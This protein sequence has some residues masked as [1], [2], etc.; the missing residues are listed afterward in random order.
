MATSAEK[1][2]NILGVPFKEYV[3]N[4]IN[5][6]SYKGST[7]ERSNEEIIYLSNK[8]CWIRLLSS[9]DINDPLNGIVGNQA[10]KDWILFGGTSYYDNG[11]NL[12]SGI[13]NIFDPNFGSSK[14][15]YGLGGVKELGFRPMPG[16]ISANIE[17]AGRAGSLRFADIKIK[18]W[19]KQQ[20]DNIEKLYF[21]LGYSCLLE[22]GHSV[23]LD[24]TGR[25]VPSSKAVSPIDVFGS[26][27][28]GLYSTKE[29][30]ITAINQKKES[31]F[32]NY[33]GLFGIIYNY[34]WSQAGDGSYDCTLKLVGIGSIIDSLK[35]NQAYSM[36]GSKDK[37]S[38]QQTNNNSVITK[39]SLPN[40][41]LRSQESYVSEDDKT[42]VFPFFN[43][44]A[45]SGDKNKGTVELLYNDLKNNNQAIFEIRY[46]TQDGKIIKGKNI[47]VI[48]YIDTK[49]ITTYNTS[50]KG[51][52]TL[53]NTEQT[54]IEKRTITSTEKIKVY[55]NKTFET[56]RIYSQVEKFL[57]PYFGIV[58][59][60]FFNFEIDKNQSL[61]LYKTV[62]LNE[63]LRVSVI[64][65]Q[66]T[67]PINE[68]QDIGSEVSLDYVTIN[69]IF[70]N[71]NTAPKFLTLPNRTKT[72]DLLSQTGLNE[73]VSR[74]I[75]VFFTNYKDLVSKN[76][77]FKKKIQ[78][79]SLTAQVLNGSI[80]LTQV[81]NNSVNFSILVRVSFDS[82]QSKYDTRFISEVA[83]EYINNLYI[84]AEEESKNSRYNGGIRVTKKYN[85]L[86]FLSNKF[87]AKRVN[88]ITFEVGN[89]LFI[90]D[91]ERL[92]NSSN[93][94]SQIP[95]DSLTNAQTVLPLEITS[96]LD[97]FLIKLRDS[98]TNQKGAVDMKPE[99]EEL[100]SSGVLD[101]LRIKYSNTT[102]PARIRD[103]PNNLENKL[104]INIIKGFNSGVM[105]GD[106]KDLSKV[107]NVNFNDPTVDS[108]LFNIFNPDIT[109]EGAV[110][111]SKY[112]Y[113][114]LGLL[115]YT[116]NNMCLLYERKK[117]NKQKS[118]IVYID[119]NPDTNYCLSTKYHFS[120]DPTIC[121]IPINSS[122]KAY[123][124]LFPGDI[125]KG[126]TSN[127]PFIL[128][129]S[130]NPAVPGDT[131]SN[132]IRTGFAGQEDINQSR[133]KI[134]NI[135]VNIDYILNILKSQSSSN[136]D[137]NVYL[138]SFL[139]TIMQDISK[140]LGN[141]NQFRV[142]YN[143]EAN[144]VCIYEDQIIN[145]PNDQEIISKSSI[146]K[147]Q[148]FPS[149]IPVMGKNSIV[150]SLTLKT[151]V[152]TKIGSQIA[153]SA[154]AG[155]FGQLNNDSS[156]LGSLNNNANVNLVD[157]VM[158][159]KEIA[160]NP[161]NG[162][163]NDEITDSDKSAADLFN[164]N[165]YDIYS[166]RIYNRQNIEI[167]KNYYCSA[168]NRLKATSPSSKSRISLPISVEIGMDGITGLSILEG[169]ILPS[170]VLPLQYLDER[171]RT[172]VGFAVSGLSHTIQNNQWT[173]T[174]KG[175]MLP[176][177]ESSNELSSEFGESTISTN[178]GGVRKDVNFDYG[179]EVPVGD[180]NLLK[181]QEFLNKV[182]II[183]KKYGF[184]PYDML[185]VFYAES[186]IKTTAKNIQ[187]DR[188]VAAGLMQWT[189]RSGVL[190]Y[191]SSKKYN[192]NTLQDILKLDSLQQLDLVDEYFKDAPISKLNTSEKL[193]FFGLYQLVFLPN[194]LPGK[195]D[196]Q[197]VQ[198][199]N[200][201]ARIIS[202]QNPRVAELAG[203]VP[204]DTLTK[205]D[206]RKYCNL[207]FNIKFPTN[208]KFELT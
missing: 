34:E 43:D 83:E 162:V 98:I 57:N 156:G 188:L 50:N 108:Y 71:K 109:D 144:T 66:V 126:I 75:L 193:S 70:I 65:N 7:L 80:K 29:D 163:G 146:D 69:V 110:Q 189:E 93:I 68:I 165:L 28:A 199:K 87:Q 182:G 174:I 195:P 46:Q 145:A 115:F 67:Y 192:V 155:N 12:R 44:V 62:K 120:V 91:E 143:D 205:G 39:S 198:S 128:K 73:K 77:S 159:V 60:A 88:D 48:D 81:K 107:P 186:R 152:S 148:L 33:D 5:V 10:A 187:E 56:Y 134:M 37:I 42:I 20:L 135:G 95:N 164:T 59:S 47:E 40:A 103:I 113:I 166:K 3:R 147:N 14:A 181:N 204:G 11:V 154:A 74:P 64:N 133:G 82:D 63:P 53:T 99:I 100:L 169:F 76:T 15:A 196:S 23:Y 24:N 149:E 25:L 111:T 130:D 45:I 124:S 26:E 194:I 61:K 180:N 4:Q 36:P 6:R 125:Y 96:N 158:Q 170:D 123:K 101:P 97:K 22:W 150:R 179:P 102:I 32:G 89:V 202:K 2:T 157:R 27:S 127:Y 203:K 184:N 51:S 185:K 79:Q 121:L 178:I 85:A 72:S 208:L 52:I 19:N 58:D 21:R 116:I 153:I 105:S 207:V 86:S 142:G 106:V 200:L 172:K 197:I 201:S 78:S 35:I 55:D 173:S 38:T 112:I 129:E 13:E 94:L 90:Y 104:Y 119:F 117:S 114:K 1:F 177:P 161:T 136:P 92:L 138:R 139:E 206:F 171:G 54:K 168:A 151:D 16:I 131:V 122:E 160:A 18:V 17:H 41:P 49:T 84:L 191:S 137:S 141:I 175:I 140:C 31:S 176:L 183:C 132:Q 8:N 9:V 30:I 190:K 167:S 118:P